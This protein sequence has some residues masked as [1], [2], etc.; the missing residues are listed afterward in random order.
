MGYDSQCRG[1]AASSCRL[2]PDDASGDEREINEAIT[3]WTEKQ[4]CQVLRK[5]VIFML[6]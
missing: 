2:L 1:T 4:K 3:G 6:A 5:L